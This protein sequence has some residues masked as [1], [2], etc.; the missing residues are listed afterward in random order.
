[1][2][3]TDRDSTDKNIELER[4]KTTLVALTQ[5]VNVLNDVKDNN[6]ENEFKESE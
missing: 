4:L 6:F 2:L 1:M 3:A 5:K